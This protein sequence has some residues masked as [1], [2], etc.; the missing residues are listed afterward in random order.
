V[1]FTPVTVPLVIAHRPATLYAGT[2]TVGQ[3]IGPGRYVGSATHVFIAGH[4]I[5]AREHINAIL[6]VGIQGNGENAVRSVTVDLKNGDVIT[7]TGLNE[8]IMTPQ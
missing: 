1:S 8:V 3:D 4:F 5:V 2:W 7:I 6:G